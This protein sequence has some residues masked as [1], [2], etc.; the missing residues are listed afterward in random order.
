MYKISA[1]IVLYNNNFELVEKAILS[2]LSS[3][4]KVHI[5]LLDNSPDN[6]L[7]NFCK[8]YKISYFF[9]GVNIGFGA[10]HNKIFNNYCSDSDYHILVN[11]DIE[12]DNKVIETLCNFASGNADVGLIM[13]KILYPDNRLQ[14]LARLLPSPLD[15]VFRRLLYFDKLFPNVLNNYELKSYSYDYIIDVPFVSGCFM[16]CNSRIFREVNGFDENIFLFMEDVDLT[17]KINH[18][19]YRS[20][21]YPFVFVFHDHTIKSITVY[22]NFVIYF[23]SALYYFRKWGWFFDSERKNINNKTL[24][25][26]K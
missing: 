8:P 21:I 22:K 11:P 3:T 9:N 25:Q 17:R 10:G 2:L 19:G 13:P 23:K 1:G 20:I 26:I 15:L 18:A 14:P 6:R 12:F 4:V 24:L 7:E 16:F 5:F